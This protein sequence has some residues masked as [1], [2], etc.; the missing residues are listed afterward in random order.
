VTGAAF[1]LELRL[2]ARSFALAGLG[3]MAVAAITGALFPSF[4]ESLGKVDLPQG[5]GDLLGGGDFASITGWLNTEIA[6]VYGPLVV[7]G[8]AI[9]AAAATI[10]G[11][12]ERRILAL[13]LAHP[14]SR[15]RLLLAKGAAV[16][17]LV[18]ALGG[19]CWVGLLISVALAGGGIGAGR[20]AALALHLAFLALALGALALALG[21]ATGRRAVAAGGSAAVAVAM[22]LVN[23]FAPVIDHAHWLEYLT[24]FHYYEGNDPLANGIDPGGLAVLAA[25]AAA[26]TAVAVAGFRDR[27]LRG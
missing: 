9:T 15:T 16:A 7:A 19:A 17:L 21:G 8:S 4:G 2:R 12:E 13:V 27:D 25:V 24:L 3:L 1:G 6:S 26:L 10:A 23:G 22:Y 18:A 11:E 5:V 20:L 14:V